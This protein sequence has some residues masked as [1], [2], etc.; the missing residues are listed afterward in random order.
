MPNAASVPE[1]PVNP[2]FGRIAGADIEETSDR[3]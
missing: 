1:E 3:R 2:T